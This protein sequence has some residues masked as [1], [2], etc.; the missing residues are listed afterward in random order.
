MRHLPY[1]AALDRTGLEAHNPDEIGI[2]NFQSDR[3][4]GRAYR[5][6][7]LAGMFIREQGIYMKPENKGRFYH[8]GRFRRCWMSSTTITRSSASGLTDAE[9]SDLV[10][11]LKSLASVPFQS[12]QAG[13]TS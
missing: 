8:D 4:P 7:N 1:R 12:E 5:T 10:E 3:S 11:Y 2:D 13:T 6:M 9:K